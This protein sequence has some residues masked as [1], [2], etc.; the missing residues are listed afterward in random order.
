MNELSAYFLKL[1]LGI[2]D[3]FRKEEA[4][5]M[6]EGVVVQRLTKT[7]ITEKN[8]QDKIFQI[9]QLLKNKSESA[10]ILNSKLMP[11]TLPK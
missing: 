3:R 1:L 9:K 10:E 2:Y 7:G 6:N 4:L 11:M 5:C 8:I